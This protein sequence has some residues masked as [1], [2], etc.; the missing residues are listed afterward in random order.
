MSLI[1][2]RLGTVV[3]IGAVVAQS[4]VVVLAALKL[5]YRLALTIWIVRMFS[6]AGFWPATWPDQ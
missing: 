4:R 5:L 3:G 1:G 2:I 6:G